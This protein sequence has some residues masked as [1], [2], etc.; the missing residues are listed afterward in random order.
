M[1]TTRLFRF[2]RSRAYSSKTSCSSGVSDS[3]VEEGVSW[4]AEREGFVGVESIIAGASWAC[5]VEL[6]DM[7]ISG[8]IALYTRKLAR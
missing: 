6:E 7:P 2:P 5:L 1:I 4:E 3:A 8:Y